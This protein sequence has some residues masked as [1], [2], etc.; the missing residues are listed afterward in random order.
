MRR[1]SI[2]V[3]AVV[4]CVLVFG[5]GKREEVQVVTTFDTLLPQDTAVLLYKPDIERRWQRFQGSALYAM[6]TD[7]N[8]KSWKEGT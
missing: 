5:C 3:L 2:V 1:L 6:W 7:P 8:L 4:A